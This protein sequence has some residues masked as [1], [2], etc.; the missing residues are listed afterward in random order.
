MYAQNFNN[1]DSILQVRAA[2]A[3]KVKSKSG[4]GSSGGI[5]VMSINTGAKPAGSIAVN[6]DP[7]Y[8]T[9]TP[10]Q[11]IQEVFVRNGACATVFNVNTSIHGWSGT[12]G[13]AGA[14][15]AARGFAYFNKSDSN[16]PITEGLVLSSGDVRDT[17]GPNV[18]SSALGGGANNSGSPDADLQ[19]LTTYPVTNYG[20][21]EFDF[22]PTAHVLEFKYIFASEEYP[23]YVNSAFNDVF[24]FFINDV[25]GG[26]IQP[27]VNIARLPT[28]GTGN[29]NVTINNVNNGYQS[30]YCYPNTTGT[31]PSNS[32]YFVRNP[33]NSVGTEMDGY[34]VVLTATYNVTPCRTYRLKLVVGNASDQILGSAVFLQ[35]RSFDVGQHFDFYGN[36]ILGNDYIFKGCTNNYFDVTRT[37]NTNQSATIQVTHTNTGGAIN[38]THYG[39]PSGNA[40]NQNVTFAAG[41]TTKRVYLRAKPAAVAGSHFTLTM[42]CP[43][44]GSA[45][46]IT[47]D[48]YI[49]DFITGISA[50][51]T[52]ACPSQ[53]NGKITVNVTGTSGKYEYRLGS[54]G[55]WQT[56][57]VFNVS[58]GTYTVY[59]RDIGTCVNP[60]STTVTVS[61][62]S[63]NANAGA[64]IN[65]CNNNVFTLA[66]NAPGPNESG[67]WTRVS[68]GNVTFTNA[69]L[70]NTK[71]TLTSGTTATLRWTLNNGSCTAYDDVTITNNALPTPP[72]VTSP[73]S[74]CLG[75]T[76]I[77]L[78][79]SGSG[80]TLKWYD[81]NN[82]FLGTT[83]PTPSTT[84]VGSTVYQVSRVNNATNC[85]SPKASITVEVK[86]LPTAKISGPSVICEENTQITLTF[87]LTGQSMWTITYIERDFGD[88]QSPPT[89]TTY[90]VTSTST[91]Y[92]VIDY[93]I[94]TTE[95]IITK[96]TDGLNC[97]N[98]DRDSIKVQFQPCGFKSP[99]L[100]WLKANDGPQ[101]SGTKLE[102]LDMSQA[103][104][105]SQEAQKASPYNNIDWQNS[106]INFNRAIRFNGTTGQYL[107]G[108]A[109]NN[110]GFSV[111]STLFT[112]T[113]PT[114][115]SAKNFPQGIF[116]TNNNTA[117]GQGIYFIKPSTSFYTLGSTDASKALSNSGSTNINYPIL[118][119]GIFPDSITT[120]N[121]K[122][123]DN[124]DLKGTKT[125]TPF[126]T[127][128]TTPAAPK[129]FDVGGSGISSY[130]NVFD[131]KIA[132]II[133]FH[134]VLSDNEANKVES[135]LAIKYGISLKKDYRASDGTTIVWD[136]DENTTFQDHITGIGRDNGYALD[137][138]VSHN[139]SPGDIVTVANNPAAF[140]TD[141]SL[142]SS[143]N[144]D[145][146]YLVWASNNGVKQ[147]NDDKIVGG[148]HVMLLNRKWRAH[149]TGTVG[150]VSIQ[151]DTTGI[152]L[153]AGWGLKPALVVTPSTNFGSSYTYYS[154]A[155]GYSR[156]TFHNV[157]LNHTSGFMHFTLV[158]T[159]GVTA[160]AGP[161]QS[162]CSN[163]GPFNEFTMAANTP[164]TNQTGKWELVSE[165]S[166]GAV[167]I[168]DPALNTTKVQLSALGTARLRWIVWN[169][170]SLD[171]DTSYVE[172]TRYATPEVPFE[173]TLPAVCPG[174]GNDSIVINP[175]N[176]NYLYTVYRDPTGGTPIISAYGTGGRIVIKP[177]NKITAN[178]C[179]YIEIQ[180]TT[181]QCYAIARWKVC[182]PVY[183]DMIHPDIRIKVCPNPAYVLDLYSYLNAAD[184]VNVSF[185]SQ[186]ASL[187]T[188]GRYINTG[189]MPPA[190][191]TLTYSVTGRC[192]SNSAK[193]YI[194]SL[195]DNQVLPLPKQVRI[196]WQVDLARHVQ[197]QQILG[198]DVAGGIWDFDPTLIDN[199]LSPPWSGYI[200]T[201]NGAYLFNAQKAWLD[202]KGTLVGTERHFTFSYY[203]NG[204]YCIPN[205]IYQFTVIVT[206]NIN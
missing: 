206:E 188:G 44:E 16:F 32:N 124:G 20:R 154:A 150:N 96:V 129:N 25:T 61:N 113:D 57:N 159:E 126:E 30:N 77:P 38:G 149:I 51:P 131:G 24:G 85:E 68:G 4:S 196:C 29:Y 84:T 138:R 95:Y 41:E 64:D 170:F 194:Q 143:I 142:A 109:L 111:K 10:A 148:H 22:I 128:P 120:K 52:S 166:S 12:T 202:G 203:I 183:V 54:S 193:V 69:N 161:D 40:V 178:T 165:P 59:A 56:S 79:A 172:I 147:F 33:C 110:N 157:N 106:T 28:T 97:V 92:T 71:V 89:E 158:L 181:T 173:L 6:R 98:N 177:G 31:N 23:E 93:P 135:Y 81:A 35:A 108:I 3:A 139:T 19:G 162:V 14:W 201:V 187:I 21:I 137:Q 132:E 48:I 62:I 26:V 46:A 156:P 107:S 176:S 66:A 8:Q 67:T 72:T 167:T 198:L 160:D 195:K 91:N 87:T 63:T 13:S 37:I 65:N 192:H 117:V 39:D 88:G 18:S 125:A 136:Y 112:V 123:W 83:A 127:Y 184:I 186:N 197:L 42:M 104:N 36:Q 205:S 189:D 199:M 141:Q 200:T 11:L 191:Y 180:H 145:K 86:A 171:A 80:Y 204:S 70:Y 60:L 163:N 103:F 99:M 101:I 7:A 190:T 53:A 90:T 82:V 49:Y 102:W 122:F 17:E 185:N 74:Y 144:V 100:L 47:K 152:G 58:A 153:P 169:T 75:A 15:G 27:K 50:S 119:R 164:N 115:A 34:T 105:I 140:V 182:I 5:S 116:S 175:S 73:V 78:T 174:V 121:T 2:A 130:A 9:M 133:Y 55:L 45:V 155:P 94:H 118:L 43:C 1:L 151:F 179:Y 168:L 114:P 146:S 76:A 134:D